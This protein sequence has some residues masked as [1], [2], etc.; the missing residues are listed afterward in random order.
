MENATKALLIAGG[1]FIIMLII[2]LL[3]VFRSQLASYM[4]EKHNE[5]IV[6][7]VVEVNSKFSEYQGKEI[8]GNELISIMNRIIDYNNLQASEYGYDKISISIDLVNRDVFLQDV[9]YSNTGTDS[10]FDISGNIIKNGNDDSSIK[11]IANL[12][13]KLVADNNSIPNINDTKLQ[14]LSANISYIFCSEDNID[15]KKTRSQKLTSILGYKV[16]E[17]GYIVINNKKKNILQ[18]V[19]NATKQYYQLTQFKRAMFTCTEIGYNTK[20]NG[21]I[22]S[23]KFIIKTENGKIVFN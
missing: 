21:R 6:A 18:S 14:R 13:S 22:N 1:I 2:T 5:K 19:Q 4:E 7:Q 12:S 11:K 9:K 16:D 20:D 3:V 10:I 17:D 8:R 15:D 23:M